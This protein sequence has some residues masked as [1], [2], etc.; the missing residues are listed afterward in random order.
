MYEKKF[1]IIE[2]DTLKIGGQGDYADKKN[3]Y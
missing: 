1:I 3:D 2:I